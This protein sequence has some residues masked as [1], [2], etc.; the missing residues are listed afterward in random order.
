MKILL[1]CPHFDPDLHAATGE[2][3]TKLALSLAERGHGID[4]VT[5]LPWYHGHSVH[6]DWR[7]RPWRRGTTATGE[8]VRVW[9]F[10]VDKNNIPARAVGFGGFAT[11]ATAAALTMPRPDVVMGMSPP[12]LLGETAYVVA[13]R[14]RVPF[15]FNVQDIFPDVAVDLGAL[16]NER[17]IA[18]ARRHERSLY[19]RADAVTVLSTD[20][21]RNVLAKL[22]DPDDIDKVR[23]IHNFA[24]TERIR[25]VDRANR[26]REQHGLG[27]KTVVM[28]SG[29][30]GLSQ[31][32]DLIEAAARHFATRPDVHFVIN[33]E[34][35][36]RPAVDRWASAHP[37]VTVADF[38]PRDALSE[39]LGAAD[40]HLILLKPGLA[41]SSTPSKMYGILAA[42]RP[43]LASIDEDSEVSDTIAAA[44]AGSSVPPADESAFL[45]ELERLLSDPD[46]LR[47]MGR[48][49]RNYIDRRFTPAAQA[50]AFDELFT[51]L[52]DVHD[53]RLHDNRRDV[54]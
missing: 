37:N 19:R 1:I 10:P 42:G 21:Q 35:A 25:V 49:A 39:T 13:R 45:A 31:S 51:E 53:N 14:H 3:M 40:L 22:D 24:D 4:V 20:Q 34:G 54:S 16:S 38:S 18:L 46:G 8:I 48:N 33:G 27:D 23:I 26:Y 12:I 36:A 30:V 2:V 5:S 29:N 9:P 11:L 52:I 50:E 41:K 47:Q 15:V 32:F 44:S 6:R 7:G 28:Y 17:V 43:V